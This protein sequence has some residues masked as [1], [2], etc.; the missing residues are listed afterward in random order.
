MD[1]NA[2]RDEIFSLSSNEGEYM[3][4]GGLAEFPST[5]AF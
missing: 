5:S 2:P 1:P 4:S 3:M